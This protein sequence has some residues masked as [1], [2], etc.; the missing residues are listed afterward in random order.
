MIC[1]CS[2]ICKG[3]AYHELAKAFS[4]LPSL[5]AIKKAVRELNQKWNITSIPSGLFG[6]QQSLRERLI[7]R[8]R[9]L[10]QSTPEDAPFR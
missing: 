7:H 8:I 9:H 10:H 5:D 3:E 1:F 4:D 6:V 2:F